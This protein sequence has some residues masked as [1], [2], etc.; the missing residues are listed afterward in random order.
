MRRDRPSKGP[1]SFDF[2]GFT[3]Y[4]T[5][6]RRNW[7]V[8][9]QKTAASRIRRTLKAANAWCRANR[10]RPIR[11]QH[12]ILCQKLRGHY[13]YFGITGNSA[14]LGSVYQAVKR[15]WCK[16]LRRRSYAAAKRGWPRW[17]DL[18]NHHYPLP[19][20]VAVHSQ[21]RRRR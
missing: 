18:I 9:K 14:C 1:E 21:L 5:R 4:W 17:F 12:Q 10:H 2:L 7:W 6:S 15:L 20:P 3:H 13:G 8:V 16:W 19:P 11:D